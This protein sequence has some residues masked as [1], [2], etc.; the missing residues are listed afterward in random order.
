MNRPTK[1]PLLVGAR[2]GVEPRRNNKH[3]DLKG[4]TGNG[5]RF[6][7]IFF[8]RLSL[9]SPINYYRT[10]FSS[11]PVKLDR[12]WINVLC[13]FHD[14]KDPSLSINLISG[15][16]YCFGCGA[17][18]GDVIAFHMQR[19]GVPFTV[20]VTFFGAWSYEQ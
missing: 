14:D 20:A 6:G 8:D 12:E 9:P 10:H 13:C 7:K 4:N 18:G 17:K 19:Y 1:N 2:K 3:G 16:F 11:I 15:G 5:K